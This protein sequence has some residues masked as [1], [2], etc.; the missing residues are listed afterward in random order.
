[1]TRSGTGLIRAWQ[2]CTTR[3]V[4]RGWQTSNAS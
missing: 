3:I 2:D 1:M 4:K